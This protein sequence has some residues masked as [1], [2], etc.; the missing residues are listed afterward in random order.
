[1]SS[2]A[3]AGTRHLGWGLRRA[4][5]EG[6]GLRQPGADHGSTLHSSPPP[7]LGELPL[8][9]C[10]LEGY[11][12]S[13]AHG[14]PGQV[15]QV[16][17]PVRTPSPQASG[18]GRQACA[19]SSRGRLHAVGHFTWAPCRLQPARL[20]AQG[21]PPQPLAL[22]SGSLACCWI[23]FLYASGLSRSSA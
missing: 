2:G 8:R 17:Q 19:E 18:L 22:Y 12:S 1:M 4:L 14:L 9:A 13:S 16:L 6:T 23:L 3:Q 20:D 21:R 5:T 10:T 7:S 11:R 15:G